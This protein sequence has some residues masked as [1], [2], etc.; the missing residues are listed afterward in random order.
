MFSTKIYQPDSRNSVIS[1][2]ATK[3]TPQGVTWSDVMWTWNKSLLFLNWKMYIQP[4]SSKKAQSSKK[5]SGLV[6][7][8]ST[9]SPWCSTSLLWQN[10]EITPCKWL[11][12][13]YFWLN[14]SSQSFLI[15]SVPGG[16]GSGVSNSP[17]LRFCPQG[18]LHGFSNT[19]DFLF[20]LICPGK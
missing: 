7:G 8:S 17:I 10:R 16:N 14:A 11:E 4:S 19:K 13:L 3:I 9:V 20:S 5:G 6:Q 18:A 1:P 12:H 2:Q 15:P